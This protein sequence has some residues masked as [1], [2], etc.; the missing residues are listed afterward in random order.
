MASDTMII[1]DQGPIVIDCAGM[2]GAPPL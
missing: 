2:N 1:G